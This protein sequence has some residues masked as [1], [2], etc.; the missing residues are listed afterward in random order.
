VTLQDVERVLAVGRLLFSV[1]TPEEIER[2]RHCLATG[3]PFR[4]DES[5][6]DGK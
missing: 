5:R 2:L 4:L 6:S 1:L 3:T